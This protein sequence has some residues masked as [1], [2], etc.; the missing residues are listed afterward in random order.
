MSLVE[1]ET[2][3]ERAQG[4]TDSGLQSHKGAH[5]NW[6][7]TAISHT[8]HKNTVHALSVLSY[9]AETVLCVFVY[10]FTSCSLGRP[11]SCP[12]NTTPLKTD[13]ERRFITAVTS[14]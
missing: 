4:E 12:L 10:T 5:R 9:A 13:R 14:L 11:E 1:R 6:T 2:E 3:R 7:I 8:V